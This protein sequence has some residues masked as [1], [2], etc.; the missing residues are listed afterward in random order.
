MSRS[1]R[2]GTF[3]VNGKMPAEDLDL[4]TW[5]LGSAQPVA[6]G[7]ADAKTLLSLPDISPF[8]VPALD[9]L[10]KQTTDTDDAA[11]T[12]LPPS[13]PEMVDEPPTYEDLPDLFVFG[14]QELDLSTGALIY[15]TPATREDAWTKAIGRAMKGIGPYVKASKCYSLTGA[16]S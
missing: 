6:T 13:P 3:N 7:D 1:A 10:S 16:L 12:P 14:F 11:A 5:V 9:P 4:R 8:A 15:A 2:I